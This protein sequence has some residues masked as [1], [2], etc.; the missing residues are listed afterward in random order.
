MQDD[1]MPPPPS[2][3]EL[4]G[5]ES[6]PSPESEMSLDIDTAGLGLGVGAG[7]EAEADREAEGAAGEE[8]EE[9]QEPIDESKMTVKDFVKQ[10]ALY[11]KDGKYSEAIIEW[12]KALDLEPDHP[13]IVESIKEA[14]SKMQ[15][16]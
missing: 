1:I 4:P 16:Q 13:E 9:G 14:M 6:E 8:T 11:F 12:Q 7:E 3:E 2:E 15:E 10:G 5:V